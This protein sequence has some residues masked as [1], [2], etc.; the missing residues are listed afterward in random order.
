MKVEVLVKNARIPQGDRMVE[1]NILIRD[2]K[3]AGFSPTA[4]IDA[5]E[6]IDAGGNLVIP[7]C[8]DSHTHIND[9]GFTHRENFETGTSAAA[10]GGVTTVIDM[11]CCSVPSVRSVA[12]LQG[13]LEA[14]EHVQKQA[15]AGV[16]AFKVYM[17]PSVPTYP[18]VTDAEMLEIFKEVAKTGLPV[19]V[20]AE[21]YNLCDY[22]VQKLQAEGRMDG[23]AWAEA[24]LSLAEKVAIEMVISFAEY[25]GVRMH[26]VHMS[27][28][29]GAIL[30]GEAKK[31]GLPVTAET[32][33]HYLTINAAAEAVGDGITT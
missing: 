28:R 7:G 12:D 6:V 14:L 9:P 20:H 29:E 8:I 26:V 25:S 11:P 22:Y 24:R 13:K 21:N 10:S 27:T 19:G 23:P 1:T 17:T 18:R 30:V 33:P 2:G 5:R 3:I 15:D 32:C 16:V 31:R 4:D